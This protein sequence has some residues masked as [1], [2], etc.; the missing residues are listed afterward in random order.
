[1]AEESRADRQEIAADG[2]DV[3]MFTVQVQDSQGRVAPL[4]ENEVTF[5]VSGP[6]KPIGVGNGGPSSHE[7]DKGSKRRAFCGLCMG[8]LQSTKGAAAAGS[9]D[10]SEGREIGNAPV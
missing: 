2:E 3:A 5:H 9:A 1:V 4:A 8:I 6:A 10:P 7:S